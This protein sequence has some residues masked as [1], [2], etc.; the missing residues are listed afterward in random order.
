MKLNKRYAFRL[1]AALLGLCVVM[2][3][4]Y[5][6]GHMNVQANEIWSLVTVHLPADLQ[7]VL[8][9]EQLY[10]KQKIMHNEPYHK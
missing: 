5:L 10:R 4:T 8:L 6:V 1:G 9:L 2:I 3:C 7:V